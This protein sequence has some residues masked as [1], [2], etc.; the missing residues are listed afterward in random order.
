V[1]NGAVA[2]RARAQ[3]RVA[4]LHADRAARDARIEDAAA[5]VFAELDGKVRAG[6]RRALA[7]QAA[8]RAVTD[9]EEAERVEVAAADQRI[10]GCV[11]AL[12]AEGLTVAQIADLLTLP[13]GEVR[14]LLR[15]A[16]DAAVPAD[17]AT[18]GAAVVG[19]SSGE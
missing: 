8:Q 2:A 7:V 5:A 16:A 18:A 13:A 12:K 10:A 9:A 1:A 15:T 3:R 4:A 6:E 19:G 17:A 11:A 14:R